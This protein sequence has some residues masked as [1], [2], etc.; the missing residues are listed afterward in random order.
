[1]PCA[2]GPLFVTVAPVRWRQIGPSECSRP[3]IIAVVPDYSQKLVVGFKNASLEVPD[4]NS[5]NV[6]VDQAADLRFPLRDIVIEPG[7]FQGDR[8]L[9]RNQF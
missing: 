6:G 5:S 2:R 8:R 4:E 1:M 7:V 3:K 9:R